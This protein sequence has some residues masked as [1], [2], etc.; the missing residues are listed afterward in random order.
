MIELAATLFVGI[1]AFYAVAAV[2]VFIGDAIDGGL[3]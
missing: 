3:H 2:L 1:C